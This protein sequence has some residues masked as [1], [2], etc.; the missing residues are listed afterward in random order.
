MSSSK[1]INQELCMYYSMLIIMAWQHI[2]LDMTV[3][4]FKKCCISGVTDMLWNGSEGDK[5]VRSEC[6]EL[7]VN[8]ETVTLIGK[9]R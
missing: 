2:S 5:N 4:G 3:K 8:M 7:T 9:G 1:F 6:A